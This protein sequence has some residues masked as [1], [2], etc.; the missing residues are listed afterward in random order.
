MRANGQR[1]QRQQQEVKGQQ[2]H[3][4]SNDQSFEQLEQVLTA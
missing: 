3:I 2:L 1:V 4:Q